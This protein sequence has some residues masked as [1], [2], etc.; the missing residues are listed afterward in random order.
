MESVRLAHALAVAN[1]TIEVRV[2]WHP[3]PFR[4]R[5]A[6]DAHGRPL[7]LCRA[8]GALDNALT[9]NDAVVLNVYRGRNQL[10]IAG[11]AA[12]ASGMEAAL[13]FA[14]SRPIGD[15]LDVGRGYGIYRVA[16]A[17]IRLKRGDGPMEE[18]DVDDYV[19][20]SSEP[21]M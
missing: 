11:W 6:L 16:V 19:A 12:P 4:V 7:L 20:V 5:H 8:G 1:G 14:T 18:I 15:L 17:E 10:W 21:V 9:A 13:E 2:V 3:H